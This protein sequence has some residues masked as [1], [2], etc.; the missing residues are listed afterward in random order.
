MQRLPAGTR[1]DVLVGLHAPDDAAV[2]LVPPGKLLVQSVDYFRA[3]IDDPYTFGQIASNHALGDL[4]AMG[5][6]PQ[7]VLAIAT[8]PYGRERAV[9]ETLHD[10]MARRRGDRGPTGGVLVGGHTSEGPELAPWGLRSM[11]WLTRTL[12][13]KGGMEPGDC[14]ILTKPLG[15]GTL[16]AADMRRQAKGRWIDTAHRLH[17]P[18]QPGRLCRL[19]APPWG[20]RLHRRHRLRPPG[21]PGGDDARLRG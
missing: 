4:Y 5:A 11:G 20:E 16:F 12:V 7:S 1:A 18:L 8:V 9:E 21:P 15:T 2:V 17:G 14:L 3:F 10:L 6:E 19:P 13:R